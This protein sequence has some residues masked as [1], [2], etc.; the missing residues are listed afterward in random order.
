MTAQSAPT[1]PAEPDSPPPSAEKPDPE[2]VWLKTVYQKGA[3]QLTVRAVLSG[4]VIGALMCLS[5]LYVVLKTGWSVGVTITACILAYAFFGVLR[6]L[7]LVKDDF[8]ALE[9]NAMG[10]VASAAGYMTGG[11]N[12]AA[13]PALLMLT[14]M[15]PD[16]WSLVF[17]FAAIAALGVFAA[18]PIKR[19]LVNVEQLAFPT[20]TATAETIRALHSHG[21]EAK[22]Q[23]RFL[24]WSG[25]LSALIGLAHGLKWKSAAGAVVGPILPATFGLPFKLAGVAAAKFTLGFEGSLLMVG[26]GGLMSFRTAWSMLLGA[27]VTWG[28]LAPSMFSQGA[29]PEA[30]YKVIIQWTLWPGAGILVSSGLVSFAFEWRSVLK[31]FGELGRLFG[32]KRAGAD[33]DPMAEVECPA[34]WF[35][36]GFGVVGPVVV[37]LCW[38]MFAIPWWAGIISIPLS[39]LMGIIAARV[40]GETDVT[41]TKAL[42]PVT[43]MIYGGV[44]PGNVVAN[45]MSA[46]V[47]G[48]VGLHAADLLTDLK[49][50]FLLG[51]NPRQQFYAQMFGVVAGAAI[52]VP[53]FNLIIPT[54]DLLGSEAFPAPGAQV[55]AGVSKVL[56]D[57]LGG[58]H[59][60]ARWATL[61]GVVLGAVL[62][63]AEKKAPLRLKPW[64]PSPAGLGIAMVIP[65]YNSVSIFIGASIAEWLRRKRPALAKQSV[66]PVSSGLLAGESL[67]GIFIAIL[68]AIGVLTK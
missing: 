61:I 12:M 68:V 27:A 44:L 23:S 35:P 30:S 10:S 6:S 1:T 21:D 9:N 38:W 32:R 53:A 42:G 50:G 15:R 24:A 31:A 57:G 26:A 40:T 49:S 22:R 25:L 29:I 28:V 13:L 41:P 8:S 11:G 19:Q 20:G 62:A 56:V 48:G 65:A 51:A 66:T 18:I 46:N 36:A 54:A 45:V 4:M 14:G 59:P 58:L 63:V 16:P 67:M 39:V 34:W 52:I 2:R 17:W 7:R 64:L 5:N 60:T 37:F 33:I 43:Q 47:T 3:R 55:W